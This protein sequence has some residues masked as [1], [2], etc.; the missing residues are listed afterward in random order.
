MFNDF[1]MLAFKNWHSRHSMLVIEESYYG[2][3]SLQIAYKNIKI[4]MSNFLAICRHCIHIIGNALV[5]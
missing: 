2:K 4:A 1:Y 5:S 3:Y